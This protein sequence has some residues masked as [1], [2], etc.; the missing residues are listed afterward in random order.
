MGEPGK[1]ESAKRIRNFIEIMESI[2]QTDDNFRERIELIQKEIEET[3]LKELLA[4]R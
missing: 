3:T 2:G 4:K 1:V